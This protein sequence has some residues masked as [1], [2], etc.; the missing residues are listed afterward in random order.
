MEQD[1]KYKIESFLKLVNEIGTYEDLYIEIL[2]LNEDDSENPYL[3]NT[4]KDKR[5]ALSNREM[6]LLK[7]LKYIKVEEVNRYINDLRLV[8]EDALLEE[9]R[10][11]LANKKLL[12]KQKFDE[13]YNTFYNSDEEEEN[14]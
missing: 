1:N 12:Q 3:I 11:N 14:V 13:D 8:K 10:E 5:Y 7:S 9:R 6:R 2:K 4:I